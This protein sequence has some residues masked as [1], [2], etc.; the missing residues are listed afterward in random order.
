MLV[1]FKKLIPNENG[2]VLYEI[3]QYL[4]SRRLFLIL[5]QD[6]ERN[7]RETEIFKDCVEDAKKFNQEIY[8]LFE[9]CCGNI[10]WSTIN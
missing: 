4:I 8:I 2:D 1:V 9:G 3:L 6:I 10:L 5:S 7:K